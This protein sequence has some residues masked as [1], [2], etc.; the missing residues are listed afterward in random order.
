MA[1]LATIARP[2]AEALFKAAGVG[3][4][5]QFAQQVQA[6]A[7]V[8]GDAQLRQFADSPKVSAAQVFD[9]I[10]SVVKAFLG[11]AAKNLLRTVIA[12]GRLAAMPEIALQFHALV[13]SRSGISDATIYS[14][15]A[16]D[17]AQLPEVVASLEK[18][19]ARKLNASVVVAPELIGGIRVVVGDEVLDT[20]VQARL[21]QMKVALTA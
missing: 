21:E 11:D 20:S 2:Y 17:A 7:D 3:D 12:N 10:T 16:I 6:L 13:N 9:L 8:A 4:Q 14:A 19:F 15:F 1:E 18:R 5:A